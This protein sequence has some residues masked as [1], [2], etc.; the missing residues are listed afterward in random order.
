MKY[1]EPKTEIFAFVHATYYE[2]AWPQRCAIC[3]ELA[4]DRRY[5]MP[6][7]ATEAFKLKFP[8]VKFH[9]EPVG[10]F[11]T[12]VCTACKDKY[13][14]EAVWTSMSNYSGD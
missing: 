7:D 11:S 12:T 6:A 5:E 2:S 9:R 14:I 8:G 4:R 1:D 3:G 13:N 10:P